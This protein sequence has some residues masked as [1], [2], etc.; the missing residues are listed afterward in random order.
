MYDLPADFAIAVRERRFHDAARNGALRRRWREEKDALARA[1]LILCAAH[2]H[3]DAG[4]GEGAR[5]K[6]G[7]AV[8]YL[9][10]LPRDPFAAMLIE[11]ARQLLRAVHEG[12]NPPPLPL[13][14]R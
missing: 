2:L 14:F 8:R 9:E 4:N 12:R 11:H 10:S 5:M 7:R 1:L 6:A 13:G 3:V